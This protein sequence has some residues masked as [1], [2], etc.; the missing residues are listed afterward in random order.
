MIN[1]VEMLCYGCVTKEGSSKVTQMQTK[2]RGCFT[3]CSDKTVTTR[4]WEATVWTR[5]KSVPASTSYH[6]V[7][8]FYLQ[9]I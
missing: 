4:L 5:M 2:S 7:Y 1:A 9:A 8:F 3:K 6:S